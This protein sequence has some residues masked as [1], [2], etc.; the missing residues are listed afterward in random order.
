MATKSPTKKKQQLRERRRGRV[1]A[2]VR[3]T[4]ERPRLSVFR[5][6]KHTVAQLVNDAAGTTMCSAR[7][8]EASADAAGTIGRKQ[9]CAFVLGKKL[10]EK[11]KAQGIT[12]IVFDRGGYAYHGRVQA[13]ADGARSGG[14]SF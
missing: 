4:A 12:A 9:Q 10:A 2:V 14:L 13:V 11:A 7:D 1:R 5:S 6:N 8:T 3:G